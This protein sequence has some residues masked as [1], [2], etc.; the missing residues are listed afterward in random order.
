LSSH[1]INYYEIGL[2]ENESKNKYSNFTFIELSPT[3]K[4]ILMNT[5]NLDLTRDKIYIL[6]I[7]DLDDDEN[8]VNSPIRNIDYKLFLQNG[9][10]LNLDNITEDIYADIFFHLIDENP[11]KYSYFLYFL[12]QGYDIY[13]KNSNFYND[14]C[15]PAYLYNNDITLSDRKKDIYPNNVTLCPDNCEYKGFNVEEKTVNCDC[16]LNTNKNYTNKTD[17]FLKEDNGNFF[18]YFLDNIN[19]GIFKCF[20]LIATYENLKKNYAFYSSISISGI[21]IIITIYFWGYGISK[22]RKIMIKET[23]KYEKFHND[24]AKEMSKINKTKRDSRKTNSM[25][26]SPPKKKFI[27]KKD[28]VKGKTEIKTKKNFIKKR[29]KKK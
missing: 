27:R 22:I 13:D 15:S 29:N 11:P 16:N 14:K 17:D 18:S 12:E 21:V 3:S 28:K 4:N 10:L 2:G 7:E 9:A 5:F 23:P 19:Y 6:I 24:Y 20:N 8:R 25:L 26:L 1:I